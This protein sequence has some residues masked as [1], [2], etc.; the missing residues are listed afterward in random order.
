MVTFKKYKSKKNKTR[1]NKYSTFRP[2][3]ININ[4]FSV[5]LLPIRESKVIRVEG[6]LY[7]GNIIENKHNAG[8]S[9]LLEHTLMESWEKC[10]KKHCSYFWEKYGVFSNAHTEDTY[11]HFWKQGLAINSD[12]ILDYIISIIVNPQITS[13][14][15]NKEAQAVRNEINMYLNKPSWK[16]TSE[17]YK[18]FYNIEG[19][20][21]SADY[22]QQLKNLNSFRKKNIE[23]F[24][25]KHFN[26]RKILFVITGQFHKNSLIKTLKQK[27]TPYT[28]PNPITLQPCFSNKKK[29]IYIQNKKAKNTN[30]K[31]YFPINIHRGDKDFP[32]LSMLAGIIGGDFNS[33]L[34][35]EL[36][37]KYELVY[38]AKCNFWTNFCGSS[39]VISISTL[40]KNIIKVLNIVF[41]IL[42]TY[43]T[44]NI[45]LNKIKS[46]REKHLI[47]FYES[48]FNNTDKISSFFKYQFLFQLHK[49]QKKIYSYNEYTKIIKSFSQKKF[50]ELFKKIFNTNHCI[51]GYIGKKKINFSE[52]D[53]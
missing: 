47:N 23:Q 44:K 53:Y 18:H 9:H 17:I 14:L 6:L 32:Y 33:L 27:L 24:F 16:L 38:S 4:G 25:K 30:I 49:K 29:V 28:S 8:I 20:Q 43:K 2:N 5:L 36:R 13:K 3:I 48:S 51:V 1:K 35:S 52:N 42:N 41:K 46:V 45:P 15:I 39:C 37:V 50:K 21:Y 19:I 10:K 22:N 7:G 31:I 34:M 40:D 11:L 12:N 26:Q